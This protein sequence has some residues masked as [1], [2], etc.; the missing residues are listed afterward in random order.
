MRRRVR[1]ELL[2]TLPPG[3]RRAMRSRQDLLRINTLMGNK[4]IMARALQQAWSGPTPRRLIEL[5]SG[6]GNFLLAVA[7]KIAPDWPEAE[8]L[9]LDRQESISPKT[10]AAFE[11]VG[12]RAESVIANVFD[13][14]KPDA[15]VV[16]A[17]LFLHHFERDRLTALLRRTSQRTKLFVALEPR[18][19]LWPLFCSRLLWA[20]GCNDVTRH[21]AA[22]SVRAGFD[23]AE[24]SGLWPDK[25]GWTLTERPAG[26]FGHLFVAR[27][28]D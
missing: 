22:V 6:D 12:W 9:L 21:D 24:L 3:D 19:A 14:P 8:V 7:K 16:V 2:D 1:P 20:V 4:G 10:L 15:D 23:G 18:R 27:R 17:N 26:A 13:W 25:K 28:R 11:A 5:G